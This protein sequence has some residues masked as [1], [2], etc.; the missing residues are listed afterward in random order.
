VSLSGRSFHPRIGLLLVAAALYFYYSRPKLCPGIRSFFLHFPI[1]FSLLVPHWSAMESLLF[2]LT[3]EWSSL[4][5]Q[6][7][8]YILWLLPL[9]PNVS[10]RV[11]LPSSTFP[12]VQST[13]SKT[14]GQP[15]G[16]CSQLIP[17]VSS[18]VA[19]RFLYLFISTS[20]AWKVQTSSPSFSTPNVQLH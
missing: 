9:A 11:V 20:V 5:L 8:L 10:G 3:Q 7:A 19:D 18:L 14:T 4:W 15:R 16:L 1:L 13:S 12:I 6:T 2:Q 17:V